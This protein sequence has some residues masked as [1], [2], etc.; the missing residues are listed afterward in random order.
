MH[1]TTKNFEDTYND[2]ATWITNIIQQGKKKKI[3]TK[4][5]VTFLHSKNR[6]PKRIVDRVINNKSNRIS[7]QPTTQPKICNTTVQSKL[8]FAE[9][10]IKK[11]MFK[12]KL[13][14]KGWTHGYNKYTT[15]A[16]VTYYNH[17]RIELSIKYISSKYTN[18][19][20]IINTILHEIAH[21]LVGHKHGHGSVWKQKAK[22][23]GCDGQRCFNH[24]MADVT[25]YK[26]SCPKGCTIGRTI[27]KK[28]ILQ[29]KKFFQCKQHKL[30]LTISLNR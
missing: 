26:L 24:T 15:S 3:T 6:V 10:N 9:E 21:A 1:Y 17:K 12:H 23:I 5:I 20:Q 8:Q 14:Q 18:K 2:L 19:K 16:G 30:R 13:T 11:L 27:I 29:G 28:D 4:D 7:K 22:E 25:K